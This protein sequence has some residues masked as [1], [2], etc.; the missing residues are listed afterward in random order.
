MKSGKPPTPNPTVHLLTMSS[1]LNTRNRAAAVLLESQLEAEKLKKL[2]AETDAARANDSN[3]LDDS[4]GPKSADS[5][6]EINDNY[7]TAQVRHV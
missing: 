2:A 4:D 7:D 3:P 1:H 6:I 5:H